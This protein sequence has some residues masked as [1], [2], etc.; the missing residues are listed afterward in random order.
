VLYPNGGELFSC[1][2]A[3]RIQ[4]A[5]D[6]DE[7]ISSVDL[8]LSLDGGLT[9]P[10]LI[11][12]NQAND[13]LYEGYECPD[14][15]GKPCQVKVTARDTD[16][17]EATDVS[18]ADFKLKPYHTHSYTFA[19]GGNV[20]KWGYGT[21]TTSWAANLQGQRLP[22]SCSTL[23]TTIDASAYTKL[24]NPDISRYMNP[25][26]AATQESTLIF[27]FKIDENPDQVKGLNIVWEGYAQNCQHME[28]YIWDEAQ[29]NWGDGKGLVGE[30]NFMDN[31]SDTD[32][33][34]MHGA[35]AADAKNYIT[36]DEVT[37]LVYKDKTQWA[38]AGYD[39]FHDYIR[40]DVVC[41]PYQKVTP[42]PGQGPMTPIAGDS[43]RHASIRRDH[44]PRRRR[45][46]TC[47][48]E[49]HGELMHFHVADL[50]T[51]QR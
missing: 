9:F 51:A 16:L 30:D 26:G 17:N 34:V 12:S 11:A 14:N 38:S 48:V 32:D 4:W 7:G 2:G 6:D 43:Q 40:L 50:A 24:S 10:I 39:T 37:I 27:R 18:D 8:Y 33:R 5:A 22:A 28:L 25:N 1:D 3:E 31:S 49:L 42:M 41:D 45:G 20:D 47:R 35:V 29:H 36:G 19:T 44:L 46:L 21:L 23:I 13:G 15:F